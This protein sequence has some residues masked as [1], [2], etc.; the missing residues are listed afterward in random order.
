MKK[1]FILFPVGSNPT[2]FKGHGSSLKSIKN[3]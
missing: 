1:V 2:I 3:G